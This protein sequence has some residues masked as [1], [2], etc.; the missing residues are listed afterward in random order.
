MVMNGTKNEMLNAGNREA[1]RQWDN[2]VHTAAQEFLKELQKLPPDEQPKEKI[3]YPENNDLVNKLI[4]IVDKTM[5]GN[6]KH[7]SKGQFLMAYDRAEGI[8]LHNRPK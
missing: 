4:G 8:F 2:D 6:G 7:L 5:K 1:M 3:P